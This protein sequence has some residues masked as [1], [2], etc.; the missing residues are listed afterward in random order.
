MPSSVALPSS[1]IGKYQVVIFGHDGDARVTACAQKLENALARFF[2]DCGVP[3]K[4]FLT[5]IPSGASSPAINRLMPVVGV[6]FGV[7]K[8]PRLSPVDRNHL[9]ALLT[10]EILIIPVVESARQFA[11]LVP[12][13]IRHLNGI[14]V[15]DCGGDFERLAAR[16]LEGFRLLRE[17]RR[18]FISYRRSD[19]SGVA[20]QLYEALD[21]AGF[22]VFLDTRTLLPG[23]PFQDIL[24]HRLADTDVVVVLDSLDF[25]AS[26][27]TE[28]E[29]AR[30]N[31]L[32][33]PLLQVLWP[34][35]SEAGAAA[36]SNFYPLS[37]DE[38][39]GTAL[40]PIA[41]LRD[42]AVQAITDEV[43]NIRA[44]AMS[45]RHAF[46]VREFLKEAREAGLSVRRALDGTII[47]SGPRSDGILVQPAIGVPDAACYQDLASAYEEESKKGKHYVAP[48]VLL[49]DQ[50]GIRE[51]WLRH[52]QWLNRNVAAVRS[53]SLVDA[54][55]W[56]ESL[57]P[58]R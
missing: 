29:L 15:D 51:K 55:A 35:Q 33:I 11:D 34:G 39:E 13:E 21:A 46:L 1:L 56:L 50:T 4:K 22:D 17:T 37:P 57:A 12:D 6:F 48:S 9:E 3:A 28:E 41:R 10:D 19:T 23:E 2:N 58:G 27:W 26:R 32:N 30:A 53:V 20:A 52:L 7:E 49:F 45:A 5:L 40:G 16:I 43:E 25:L 38:F 44:R 18:L 47:V 54:K 42:N 24:W 8:S 36:F 31:I 14:S